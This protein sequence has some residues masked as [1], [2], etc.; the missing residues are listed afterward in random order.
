MFT[1][2]ETGI[3][4]SPS[5]IA[6][7]MVVL[8]TWAPVTADFPSHIF[9]LDGRPRK[10]TWGQ[11]NAIPHGIWGRVAIGGRCVRWEGSGHIP[12]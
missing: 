9:C 5:L 10:E 7:V 6:L 2:L 1:G 4:A 11:V 3:A 12:A 8:P